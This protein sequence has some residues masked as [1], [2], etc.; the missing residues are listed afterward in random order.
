[1]F[2]GLKRVIYR[3]PDLE[4]AREWYRQ[5]LAMDPVFDSPVA[6]TFAV[7]SSALILVPGAEYSTGGESI[8]A[9]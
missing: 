1:M 3:V 5:V 8:V 6:I 2:K 7:G 9:G 4:K